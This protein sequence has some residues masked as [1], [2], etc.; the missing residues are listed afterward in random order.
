MDY[1]QTS[2]WGN[3][4]SQTADVISSALTKWPMIKSQAAEIQSRRYANMAHAALANAQIGTEAQQAGMY[5]AQAQHAAEQTKQEQNNF[6]M[7]KLAGEGVMKM[8]SGTPYAQLAPENQS[9]LGWVLANMKGGQQ[10]F[11]Q[12]LPS[13]MALTGAKF[14]TDARAL[15]ALSPNLTPEKLAIKLNANETAIVPTPEGGRD[16]LTA[17]TI[18][19]P[20]Q[21]LYANPML[22]GG[23]NW[24]A[25]AP[26]SPGS[27]S[28]EEAALNSAAG[29]LAGNMLVSE[30]LRAQSEARLLRKLNPNVNVSELTPA[31]GGVSGKTLVFEAGK[32]PYWRDDAGAPTPA[33]APK[34][35]LVVPPVVPPAGTFKET[36]TPPAP[37]PT[38]AIPTPVPLGKPAIPT[39]QLGLTGLPS[40]LN[41]STPRPGIA[42]EDEWVGPPAP[43]EALT[44][45][46]EEAWE[47]IRQNRA[48]DGTPM[49]D[50]E[51]DSDFALTLLPRGTWY[52]DLREPEP[53]Q[54]HQ[55]Q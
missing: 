48:V 1:Y 46:P 9:A 3:E 26:E 14:P 23:F 17:Q 8:I 38:S 24:E 16:Y 15:A 35:T 7:G 40:V 5:Q 21:T 55:K 39:G 49:P 51:I 19:N 43:M 33:A 2:P 53:R 22:S 50:K 31:P 32:A 44:T 13:M 34:G 54:R 28:G 18:L 12:N 4:F 47:S 37:V 27:T 45:T 36:V 52:I 11:A 30:A 10:N 41:Y 29:Q 6:D 42:R 25:T 20:G